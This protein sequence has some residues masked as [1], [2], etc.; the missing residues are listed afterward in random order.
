M[1]SVRVQRGGNLVIAPDE[2]ARLLQQL[3]LYLLMPL[4]MLTGFADWLC[5]RVQRIEHSAGLKE[6]VLHLLM[7]A[8]LGIG[9]SAALLLQV[10]AAVLA[11]LVACAIAHELTMWLDLAY[12]ASKRRIAVVEQWVHGLQQALPWIGLAMLMV[13]H[14]DQALALVG[15]GSVAADWSW[16]VKQPSLPA[17]VLIGIFAAAAIVVLIPFAQEAVRCIRQ[18]AESR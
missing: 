15:R 4:W 12:A 13:I 2:T 6:S 11:L 3:L 14:R 9:I 8:E 17:P 5:H 16:R 7:I 10:N 1:A 18:R